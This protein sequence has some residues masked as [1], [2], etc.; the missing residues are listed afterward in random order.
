VTLIVAK[1]VYAELIASII[2]HACE[3]EVLVVVIE[4][5]NTIQSPLILG[6]DD[7]RVKSA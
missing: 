2:A 5:L 6:K 1:K 3:A 7:A 4:V